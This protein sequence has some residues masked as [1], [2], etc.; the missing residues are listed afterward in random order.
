MYQ[1]VLK[2]LKAGFKIVGN[3]NSAESIYSYWWVKLCEIIGKQ[4]Y[5]KE[6]IILVAIIFLQNNAMQENI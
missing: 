6:K 1:S 4:K 5:N 2:V 3:A